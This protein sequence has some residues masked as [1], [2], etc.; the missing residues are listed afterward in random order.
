VFVQANLLDDSTSL[1]FAQFFPSL[2][3]SPEEKEDDE[4]E[5]DDCNYYNS[6]DDTAGAVRFRIAIAGTAISFCKIMKGVVGR[7]SIL[8]GRHLGRNLQ[9]GRRTR[10]G[11]G[12]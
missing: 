9:R 11:F 7:R 3:A 12:A 8:N 10:T 4:F 5:D 6:D 1:A 2:I